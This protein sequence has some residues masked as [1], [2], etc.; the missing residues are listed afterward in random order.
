MTV[1]SNRGGSRSSARRT[2]PTPS[3]TSSSRTC[4]PTATRVRSSRSTPRAATSGRFKAFKSVL[5][6]PDEI[7]LVNIS[8]KYTLVPAVLEECGKKGVKF[9][10]VHTAGFK[11]VGEEGIKRE[12]EMVELA[13]SYGMR[14]LRAELP[15]H[16]ERR[17][18]GLGLRQLHLRADETGQ[19]LDHRAGRRHGRDAQAAPSQR[20]SRPPDVLLVR[21]RV[22]SDDARDPRLLRP[23]RGHPGD[24]DADREL[25]G[26]GRLPRGGLADH[27]AQ[28]DPGHQGRAH[29]GGL[30]GGVVAHRHPRRPGRMASAMYRQGGGGRVPRHPPDD[31]GRDR[32]LDPGTA[33]RHGGSA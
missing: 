29:E 3:A 12:R 27:P 23:G 32:V 31:Q 19:H 26:P 8:V 21:Q 28:A 4:R 17:P 5:D 2:T 30:G 6:V 1:S 25:Q 9:A 13:H 14:H 18:R 33:A 20:R 16:P 15:G 11:E 22:R 10:I 24:H 7:D